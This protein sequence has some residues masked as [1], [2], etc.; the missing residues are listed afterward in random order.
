MERA[1]SICAPLRT[2]ESV[3]ISLVFSLVYH[4]P[5]L[6]S[7][8]WTRALELISR[9]PA[10]FAHTQLNIIG[11]C[12]YQRWERERERK[13]GSTRS[14]ADRFAAARDDREVA[15]T[16]RSISHYRVSSIIWPIRAARAP[17]F[18]VAL[19]G[20][21]TKGEGERASKGIGA[22][23]THSRCYRPSGEEAR[24]PS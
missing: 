14:C 16:E 22:F 19:T 3:E 5:K 7:R 4:S 9:F 1:C 24:E 13:K 17:G 15:P 8:S 12:V 23:S 10:A 21:S 11:D 2:R 18:F 20:G 6:V